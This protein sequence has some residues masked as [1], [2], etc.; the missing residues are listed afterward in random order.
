MLFTNRVAVFTNTAS[1]QNLDLGALI[2]SLPKVPNKAAGFGGGKIQLSPGAYFTT[3]NGFSVSTPF[4]LE[5]AGSAYG[6]TAIVFTN[7]DGRTPCLSLVSIYTTDGRN[8]LSTY[9]HDLYLC[10]TTDKTNSILSITNTARDHLAR[11]VICPWSFAT[12][13]NGEAGGDYG[14]STNTIGLN[15]SSIDGQQTI[16]E[17]VSLAG[18]W[19]GAAIGADHLRIH[20]YLGIENCG[21]GVPSTTWGTSIYS[22]GG[23]VFL[24]YGINDNV[25]EGLH[26]YDTLYPLIG[27]SSCGSQT[28]VIGG[29]WGESYDIRSLSVCTNGSSFVFLFHKGRRNISDADRILRFNGSSWSIIDQSPPNVVSISQE[30]PIGESSSVYFAVGGKNLMTLCRSST[31][32][33]QV[34][35]PNLTVDDN[36]TISNLTSPPIFDY[37]NITLSGSIYSSVNGTYT[38]AYTNS[39]SGY[40]V[41]TNANGSTNGIVILDPTFGS[42]M[43]MPTNMIGSY[44]TPLAYWPAFNG[45]TALS[46]MNGLWVDMNDNDNNVTGTAAF[47]HLL[48][49]KDG[50]VS[51]AGFTGNG[52]GLAGLQANSVVGTL[53]NNT[54]GNARTLSQT[55]FAAQWAGLAATGTVASATMAGTASYAT[56]SETLGV[57]LIRGNGTTNYFGTA[58]TAFSDAVAASMNGDTIRLGVGNYNGDVTLSKGVLISSALESVS[59]IQ[60]Q[61]VFMAEQ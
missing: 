44:D 23:G 5:I 29:D 18:L 33:M 39:D 32:N 26:S 15:I 35:T 51:A 19:V 40:C 12:N 52:S 17:D 43:L 4:M 21:G 9:I 54:T 10:A 57:I 45:G 31:G 41:L 61:G 2:R 36:L 60:K 1:P 59:G 20:G 24:N 50:T 34:E 6:Q 37:Y 25:I 14:R 30:G 55:N 7:W 16:L 48:Q 3:T 8:S 38:F 27:N 42:I 11:L 46:S 58:A 47:S 49:I 13:A 28:L 56:N 53:T 22:V